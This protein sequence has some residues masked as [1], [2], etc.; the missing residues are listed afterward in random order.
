MTSVRLKPGPLS[1]QAF[2]LGSLVALLLACAVCL[3]A[4]WYGLVDPA[5]ALVLSVVVLPPYLLLVACGLG[6]WLGFGSDATAPAG[7]ARRRT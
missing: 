6:V 1:M 4:L 5:E 3:V 2:N 7:I